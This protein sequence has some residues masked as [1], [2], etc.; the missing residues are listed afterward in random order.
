MALAEYG[1]LKTK[2][3]KA[4][5]DS[6]INQ[7]TDSFSSLNFIILVL[8]MVPKFILLEVMNIFI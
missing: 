2:K 4:V 6:T 3:Q 5:I 8:Y 1:I 7:M